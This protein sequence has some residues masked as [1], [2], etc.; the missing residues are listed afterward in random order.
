MPIKM[1]KYL[2][3]HINK[4]FNKIINDDYVTTSHLKFCKP[5]DIGMIYSKAEGK[6]KM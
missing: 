3:I 6:R 1:I 2:I 5:E 4:I